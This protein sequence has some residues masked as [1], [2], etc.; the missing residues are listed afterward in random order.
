MA[1]KQTKQQQM[2]IWIPV[3]ILIVGIAATTFMISRN[4]NGRGYMKMK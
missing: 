3:S 2:G 4:G 1:E